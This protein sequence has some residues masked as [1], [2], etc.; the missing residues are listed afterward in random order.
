MHWKKKPL[1]EFKD[2]RISRLFALFPR[3][4]DDGYTVWLETY[5]VEEVFELTYN[6]PDWVEVSKWSMHSDFKK[7]LS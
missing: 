1:P 3:T 6:G 4:L 2:R 7:D 5:F